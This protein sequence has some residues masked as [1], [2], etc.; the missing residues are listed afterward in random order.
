MPRFEVGSKVCEL[1]I[2]DTGGIACFNLFGQQWLKGRNNFILVY[3][4]TSAASFLKLRSIYTTIQKR[5]SEHHRVLLVGNKVD[6][7]ERQVSYEWG[8]SFAV[9]IG[10]D[11]LETSAKDSIAARGVFELIARQNDPNEVSRE[12]STGRMKVLDS[13]K[14]RKEIRYRD[15]RRGQSSRGRQCLPR[16]RWFFSF[17]RPSREFTELS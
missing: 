1:R 5:S 13:L 8:Q 4:V 15:A 12:G 14:V 7:E 6:R 11:F 9:E 10:C 3:D 2:L 17:S 16:L